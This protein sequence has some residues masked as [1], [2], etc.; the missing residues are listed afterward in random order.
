MAVLRVSWAAVCAHESSTDDMLGSNMHLEIIIRLIQLS[1]LKTF[2]SMFAVPP[3]Y[4][5]SQ[6]R[7]SSGRITAFI[8]VETAC[9]W[10]LFSNM[11]CQDTLGGARSVALV[12][13]RT[14]Q[15]F[16]WNVSSQ[17][18][19]D[20]SRIV[21]LLALVTVPSPM[22]PWHVSL[23]II[24]LRVLL[25]AVGTG[26]VIELLEVR[27]DLSGV[28]QIKVRK[29]GVV[30]IEIEQTGSLRGWAVVWN[31]ALNVRT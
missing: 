12:A 31:W 6:L 11:A 5:K 24:L 2:K 9:I 23:Q 22:Y 18:K 17:I 21:A 16:F 30:D 7:P 25:P 14:S 26:L 27:S 1:A 29:L 28:V 20:G 19:L 13:I 3:F 8:A 4:M 15:M 10:V